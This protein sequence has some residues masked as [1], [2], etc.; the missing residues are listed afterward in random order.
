MLREE[1]AMPQHKIPPD[2]V[3]RPGPR[4]L[5]LHLAT[6]NLMLLSSLAAWTSA[7]RVSPLWNPLLQPRLAALAPALAA[8]DPT[9]FSA[10]LMRI[11]ASRSEEHTSALQ[12]LMRT[13]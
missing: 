4:P 1:E 2:G 8:V 5:A 9:E 11:A 3:K 13:S 12:S 7:R 6:A 10:A